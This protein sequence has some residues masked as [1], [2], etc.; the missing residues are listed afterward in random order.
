MVAT[1][2]LSSIV[3]QLASDYPEYQFQAG[4]VFSWSHRSRTITY[5]NEA[6]QLLPPSCSTKLPTPS[7]A[8]ITIL[9]TSTSSPWSAKPGS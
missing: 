3:K 7:W 8:I 4:D 1:I 5:I 9:V 2:T 6:Y